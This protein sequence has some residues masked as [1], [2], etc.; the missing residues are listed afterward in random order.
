MWIVMKGFAVNKDVG[1]YYKS[2]NIK[3]VFTN[4]NSSWKQNKN[5]NN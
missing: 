4:K 5:T 2:W 1:Q 3:F